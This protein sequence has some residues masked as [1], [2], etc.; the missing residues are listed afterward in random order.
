MMRPL[1]PSLKSGDGGNAMER[2]SHISLWRG[3]VFPDLF[4]RD[5]IKTWLRSNRCASDT[6]IRIANQ[7][8]TAEVPKFF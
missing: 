2:R 5:Y 8:S 6:Q 1:G 7:K 3:N 4:A